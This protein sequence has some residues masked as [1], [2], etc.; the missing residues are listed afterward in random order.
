MGN[1]VVGAAVVNTALALAA[2]ADKTGQT[3]MEILDIACEP[4]KKPPEASSGYDAEFDDAYHH[5]HPF[6][7]LLLKAFQPGVK[8]DPATDNPDEWNQGEWWSEN[9]LEPFR[10]RYSFC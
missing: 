3:P 7:Q 10:K 9:V 2:V 4:W 1:H 6:A 5:E 8:Y